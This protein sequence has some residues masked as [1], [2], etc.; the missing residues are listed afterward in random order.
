MNHTELFKLFKGD[1]GEEAN[2]PFNDKYLKDLESS[3]IKGLVEEGEQDK[4]RLPNKVG[5]QLNDYNSKIRI[6][7]GS[8]NIDASAKW[9]RRWLPNSNTNGDEDKKTGSGIKA[10]KMFMLDFAADGSPVLKYVQE[11]ILVFPDPET[12]SQ[13]TGTFSLVQGG[14]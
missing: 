12:G 8:L 2:N 10:K 14:R 1:T 3:N 11:D 6:G 13:F 4:I 9:W 5:S 7:K